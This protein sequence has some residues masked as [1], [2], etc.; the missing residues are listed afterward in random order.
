MQARRFA[1]ELALL[2]MSQLSNKPGAIASQN[3]DELITA[4]VRSLVSEVQD[5][6]EIAAGD[7]QRGQDHLLDSETRSSGMEE[8]K[9]MV[10]EAITRTQTAINLLGSAV[11]IPELVQLSNR[12]ELRAYAIELITTTVRHRDQVDADL[13]TAMVAWQVKRLPQIDRDILRIAV[14]EM[15]YLGI[16]DRVAINEAI[17]IA[18]RYSDED[19]YRFIN[20]VLRRWVTRFLHGSGAKQVVEDES[21]DFEPLV[22][23]VQPEVCLRWVAQMPG[24]KSEHVFELQDLGP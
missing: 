8:A 12:K 17:E 6:L 24:F 3:L 1:R 22:T 18:K 15:Q 19:G 10:K 21:T 11:Q 2:G 9:T 20:G 23:L 7:L 13:D 16:P 4:S 5:A 14:V